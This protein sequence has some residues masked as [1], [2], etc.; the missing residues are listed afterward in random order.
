MIIDTHLHLIDRSVLD[1]PW[2]SAVPTLNRDY[3]DETYRNEALRTGIAA[4]LH[5]EV[6]VAPADI[7]RETSH[8]ETLAGQSG[9]LIAGAISAC[10]PEDPDFPAF[11]DAQLQ[12]PFVK[13]LR[14]VLHVMPDDLSE[15]T[16]F[17][18][19][20][21]RLAGT[22][23]TFDL[24]VLPRQMPQA[25]ALADLVPDCIFVLDHCGVPDIQGGDDRVWREQ[26]RDIARRPNVFGK[27]SGVIAYADPETWTA[28]TLRPYVEHTIGAFG[29]ER[30]VWGSDWPVCTLGGGLSTWV[31][32]TH[33]LLS[34]SSLAERNA[35][36]AGNAMRLWNLDIPKS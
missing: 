28:Q 35:L 10:R 11:L 24:C 30:V 4:S 2:L 27:I 23:L 15:S 32:T 9:S 29:W 14:R 36:L 25:M 1:Y 26:L 8:V 19:N 5:M 22:G 3:L 31:A 7:E 34:G 20:I 13:G 12:N 17:R 16:L 6:D 18:D 21:K 33:A